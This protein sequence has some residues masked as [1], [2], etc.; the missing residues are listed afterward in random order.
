[1][2]LAGLL[3]GWRR[4]ERPAATRDAGIRAVARTHLGRIRTIN[5]DR[6]FDG[7]SR[8]LW[9]VADGMGGHSA[10][11]IAAQAIVDSLRA[12][13]DDPMRFDD[14]SIE[15][16]LL[17]AGLRIHAETAASTRVSG[18]TIVALHIDGDHG[19]VFWAGDSRAYRVRG[20]R[21]QQLSRDHSLVQDL[22]DSGALTP[23]L[24]ERHPQ[25]HVITRALGAAAS[26][27]IERCAI[28]VRPGDLLLLCSDGLTRGRREPALLDYLGSTLEVI[29]DELLGDA[30]TAGGA[31]NIS[32]VLIA[33]G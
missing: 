15:A 8:G 26:V 32:F 1:M 16:A 9:A 21:I 25:A 5:E 14:A 4:S 6:V 33:V 22:I 31:D 17:D 23:A 28:D 7:T 30:L 11:D 19:T 13:V 27:A 29:A 18:S 10:G 12:I 24:A 20:G 3:S 2:T